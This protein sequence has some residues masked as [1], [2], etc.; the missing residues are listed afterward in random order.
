MAMV[1]VE[2]IR[3]YLDEKTDMSDDRVED[4]MQKVRAYV[5]GEPLSDEIEE[6]VGR[7][8]EEAKSWNRS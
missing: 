8:V 3:S 4:F 2:K 1:S 7:V 6:R 5:D